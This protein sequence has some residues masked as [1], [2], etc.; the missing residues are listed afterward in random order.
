MNFKEAFTEVR[1][2][3][4]FIIPIIKKTLNGAAKNL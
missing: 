2:K 3:L 4:G 1:R